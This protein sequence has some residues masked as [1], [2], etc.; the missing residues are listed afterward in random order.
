MTA[1]EH[2]FAFE[3]RRSEN[4]WLDFLRS[5]AIAFVLARHGQRAFLAYREQDAHGLDLIMINGWVGV[6]LFLVLSGYLIATNLIRTPRQHRFR[7]LSNYLFRRAMR[8]LPAYYAA[9]FLTVAGVFP[10][11]EFS[12]E[13]LLQRIAY[14]VLF[15]QDYFP[16]DINVTFWSLGVEEKFYLMAPMI[17]A[18]F[19]ALKR[20]F[21]FLIFCSF[22]ISISPLLRTLVY[23]D[24]ETDIDY[25]E[26]WRVFRSPFH[27]V[28]EPL[29]LGVIVAMIRDRDYLTVNTKMAK[30]LL[31]SSL[32][33]MLAWL[34]THELMAEITL[35]DITIQPLLLAAVF[36]VAVFAGSALST[37][38]IP[39]EA[40]FRVIARLSFTLYLVH[41]PL[42]PFSIALT[43]L[44]GGSAGAF[45]AVFLSLS[46]LWAILLHFAIEKPFLMARDAFGQRGLLS[47]KA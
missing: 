12:N 25:A 42:L 34:A 35:I 43:S 11:Y 13:N 36:A 32:L 46:L 38:H 37:S 40:F 17:V 31:L 6:D 7:S 18:I 19:A 5:L 26:F 29:C 44:S 1:C 30:L 22:L 45:W 15:L 24:M 47:Q 8:I 4:P 27:A 9:L 16:S 28:L 2:Y 39:G 21:S 33:V 10:L 3:K 14:H 20:S 41:Y 23:F